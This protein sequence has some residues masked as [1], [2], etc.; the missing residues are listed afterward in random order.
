MI[1]M[2]NINIKK[3]VTQAT[4]LGV[5]MGILR[6]LA[7]LFSGTLMKTLATP[8]IRDQNAKHVLEKIINL[9]YTAILGET[10]NEEGIGKEW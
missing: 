3:L 4:G 8:T 2:S 10:R 9:H 6:M 1:K 5:R 7:A